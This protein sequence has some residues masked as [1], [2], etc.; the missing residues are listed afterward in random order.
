MKHED[1]LGMRASVQDGYAVIDWV[2]YNAA[3]KPYATATRELPSGRVQTYGAMHH[4]VVL[5]SLCPTLR[6][7]WISPLPHGVWAVWYLP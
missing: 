7:S 5:H 4:R 1:R 2:S 6:T 3:V